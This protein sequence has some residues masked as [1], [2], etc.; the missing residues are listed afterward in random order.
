MTFQSPAKPGRQVN[1]DLLRIICMF[2]V[3]VCRTSSY[4]GS[5][6]GL[7]TGMIVSDAALLCGLAARCVFPDFW[8]GA[9][10]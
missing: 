3:V 8:E 5:C 1:W 10:F 6:R 2:L 9:Y 7:V 4:I